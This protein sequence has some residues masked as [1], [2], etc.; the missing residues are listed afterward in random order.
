MRRERRRLM[1]R[2]PDATWV[3]AELAAIDVLLD[4]GRWDLARARAAAAAELLPARSCGPRRG[5]AELD[6]AACQAIDRS[7][8]ELAEGDNA[9]RIGAYLPRGTFRSPAAA[10]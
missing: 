5:S 8:I 1:H 7:A 4:E 6:C 3:G 2:P 9:A 10:S